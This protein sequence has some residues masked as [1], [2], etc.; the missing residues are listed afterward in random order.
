[1][2]SMKLI[3][4]LALIILSITFFSCNNS[5]I[6]HETVAEL[7]TAAKASIESINSKDLAQIINKG[8]DLQIVDCREE[9]L[10]K[11]GHIT[12]SIN[13]PRGILE[14]SGKL[15]NRRL[16]TIVF[17]ND[18]GSAALAVQSLHKLKYSNCYW[19]DSSWEDWKNQFPDLVEKGLPGVVE[20][21]VKVESS[22]GGCGD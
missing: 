22:G 11:E 7:V 19:V 10:Y 3:T 6:K 15:S 1:M 9:N 16:N 18:Q 8:H 17:G 14:F 21:V 2:R 12:G 20:E 4:H 5:A 13:I